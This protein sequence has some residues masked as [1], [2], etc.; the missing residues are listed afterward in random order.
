MQIITIICRYI[1]NTNR[2]NKKCESNCDLIL[3]TPHVKEKRIDSVKGGYYDHNFCFEQERQFD[4]IIATLSDD[5]AKKKTGN[6]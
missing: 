1:I 3:P 6:L 5:T 4:T 2:R